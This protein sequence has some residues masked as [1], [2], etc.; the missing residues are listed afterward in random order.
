MT[1]GQ[2][3]ELLSALPAD[4]DVVLYTSM[5]AGDL[6]EPTPDVQLCRYHRGEPDAWTNQDGSDVRKAVF[7]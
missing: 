5:E 1:V 7:L 6:R 4:L 3:I 2:L